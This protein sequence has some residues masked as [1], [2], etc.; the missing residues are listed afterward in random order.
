MGPGAVGS[1]GLRALCLPQK[2]SRRN[3][4]YR[5]KNTSGAKTEREQ[6]RKRE[7]E[8]EK[9]RRKGSKQENMRNP[10]RLKAEGDLELVWV[11]RVGSR[12]LG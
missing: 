12:I 10:G 6:K 1:A 7:R 5:G 11:G 9:E 8:R 4:R 2:Q 3:Y